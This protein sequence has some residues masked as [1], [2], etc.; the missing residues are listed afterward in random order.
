MPTMQVGQSPIN[1][2]FDCI[3]GLQA[4][5]YTVSVREIECSGGIGLREFTHSDVIVD[6]LDNPEGIHN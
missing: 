2:A 1:E 4:R 6:G 3:S 5:N